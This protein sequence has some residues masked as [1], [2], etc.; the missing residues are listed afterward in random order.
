M[1]SVLGVPVQGQDH[2][3]D[4]LVKALHG[5][6]LDTSRVITLNTLS[7]ESLNMN[8][9]D[10]AHY[11]AM[12]ALSAAQKLSF[13]TGE[14]RAYNNLGGIYWNWGKYDEALKNYS[15]ALDLSTRAGEKNLMAIASNN[16]GL[17][18]WN[19]GKYSEA[20]K[21][22]FESLKISKQTGDK[23]ALVLAYNNI[24]IIY[25]QQGNYEEA[26]KHYL[27]SISISRETG[28]KKGLVLAN[29]NVGLIYMEQQKFDQA[30][31]AYESS[32]KISTEMQ[33]K[34]IMAMA[35]CNIALVQ[36]RQEKFE[37]SAVNH[38]KSLE[39]MDEIGTVYG[40]GINYN[41]LGRICLNQNKN[42][43]ARMW[44]EKA[45]AISKEAGDYDGIKNCCQ[46]MFT[47]DSITGNWKDAF[48]HYKEYIAT[49]D[50]LINEENTKKSLEAQMEYEYGIK[51]AKNKAEHDKKEA[52]ARAEIGKQK[53]IRNSIA[54][55]TG[56]LVFSSVISF[57]FYKRRR[58]EA[59]RKKEAELRQQE[60]ELKQQVSEVEM[61]ALRSQMNP[62]FI[63]N[64]LNSIYRYMENHDIERAGS[65]LVQ[66]SKL[67]RMILENSMHPEV[68]LQEDI[69][70]LEL[71]MKM[72][73]M[74][75]NDK[76][77]FS[78][79]INEA[80]DPNEI[81]V[82]PLLLQPF[83][84]N[85]IWHGLSP[86][87]ERGHISIRIHPEG[88]SMIRCEVEDNGVG[89]DFKKTTESNKLNG[90]KKS[91]GM[92]ITKERIEL[93]NRKKGTN[94]YFKI[95][96]LKDGDNKGIGSKVEVFLP[97]LT[98]N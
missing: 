22:F 17:V 41:S 42:R 51:E 68:T 26:L 49:R 81:L 98:D 94:G 38:Y 27:T 79:E 44:L 84:E 48:D 69:Q 52:L 72:E 85:A 23:K 8:R 70:G 43:E 37:E 54:G 59:F 64:S 16:I 88:D 31:A 56:I 30:L 13:K 50:S 90:H 3:I 33:D 83:V 86:K 57:V 97:L 12:Q 20:L 80:L 95:I 53:V 14:I 67:I 47:L 35:Y 32:L 74:R 10:T 61:K 36:Y 15:T 18:Y 6:M 5:S 96:D 89:R 4:S 73:S 2:K 21:T 93:I 82:P 7:W 19:Q 11:Y 63:F 39:L 24:G 62:H 9:F 58:D 71:Y 92:A 46:S 91:L 77:D 45:Y 75:L 66:F 60:A 76:F 34:K 25:F 40:K 65:Y 78:F 29:N 87:E 28:D 1:I 55:G